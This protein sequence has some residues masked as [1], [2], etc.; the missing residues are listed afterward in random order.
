MDFDIEFSIQPIEASS[1]KVG[2]YLLYNNDT[3]QIL[4]I[5]MS[6]TGKHGHMKCTFNARS[7]SN[8]KKV[9]IMVPG[10][11]SLSLVD[12][13]KKNYSLMDFTIHDDTIT[14]QVLDDNSELKTVDIDIE[15]K[16]LFDLINTEEQDRLVNLAF[17]PSMQGENILTN[18]LLLN[19]QVA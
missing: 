7:L 19:I 5:N 14:I 4:K 17:Y 18:V 12:L 16:H 8:D 11:E 10:H 1:V 15:R 2:D 9:N 6:K 3:V 13:V